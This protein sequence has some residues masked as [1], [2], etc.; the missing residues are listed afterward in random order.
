MR[1]VSVV[2]TAVVFSPALANARP[3]GISGYSGKTNGTFCNSCHKGGAAP[4]VTLTGPTSLMAGQVGNYSLKI[5]GGAAVVGGLDVATNP[6]GAVLAGGA[7]TKILSGELVHSAPG[8]FVGGVL[9]YD[10]TLTAPMTAGMITLYAAGNST[11]KDGSDNGDLAALATPLQIKVTA[12]APTPDAGTADAGVPDMGAPDAG[13]ADP[14][15]AEQPDAGAP[16]TDPG[17]QP[18]TSSPPPTQPPMT[19]PPGMTGSPSTDSEDAT[20]GC[21]AVSGGSTLAMV[22]LAL[23]LRKRRRQPS[24]RQP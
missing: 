12:S 7:G 5:M 9:Q 3:N 1:F 22:L 21:S 23:A 11:N 6:T 15:P 2:C 4:V 17:T 13:Q 14:P 10:F 19:N 18:P 24:V 20:G 8:N 16:P